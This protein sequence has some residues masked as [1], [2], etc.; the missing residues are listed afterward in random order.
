MYMLPHLVF[1][2]ISKMTMSLLDC[3][4]TQLRHSR[5]AH[6]HGREL[7]VLHEH[8]L[9]N[10]TLHETIDLYGFCRIGKAHRLLFPSHFENSKSLYL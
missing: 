7:L 10:S 1:Q 8:A 5:L 9:H 3:N 6:I 2:D 4:A